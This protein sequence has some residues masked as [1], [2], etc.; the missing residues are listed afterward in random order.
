MNDMEAIIEQIKILAGSV[1][2]EKYDTEIKRGYELLVKLHDLG[3]EKESVYQSLLAYHSGLEDGITYN[4]I[5]DLLD[6]VAGWCSASN[7]IWKD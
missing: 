2:E 3:A 7:R 4:Y 5:A 6:Y 1:N